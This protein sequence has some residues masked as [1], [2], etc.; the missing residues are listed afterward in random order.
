[1]TL[2][3]YTVTDRAVEPER[4]GNDDEFEIKLLTEF[5]PPEP[6][7][8][9]SYASSR[10]QK[11]GRGTLVSSM[12]ESTIGFTVPISEKPYLDELIY[13]LADYQIATIDATDVEYVGAVRL[14][15]ML[16]T[17]FPRII[18]GCTHITQTMRIRFL[19]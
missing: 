17:N 18:R 14:F 12:E 7:F 5:T 15:R 4:L 16:D 2:I 8:A 10:D 9:R 13:S 11:S 3:S 1:M 6:L 19:S